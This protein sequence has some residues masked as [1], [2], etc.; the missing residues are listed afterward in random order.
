MEDQERR[1]N[2]KDSKRKE[3]KR[4]DSGNS[5]CVAFRGL[6]IVVKELR[7]GRERTPFL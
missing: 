3:K 7:F 6:R 4:K 1:L 5:G 2:D